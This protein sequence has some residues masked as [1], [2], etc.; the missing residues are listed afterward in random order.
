MLSIPVVQDVTS[1]LD[2]HVLKSA[3]RPETR[4]IVVPRVLNGPQ[5][6]LKILVW[7]PRRNPQTGLT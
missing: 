7:T 6:S 3:T 5:R 1:I 2:Y 4:N